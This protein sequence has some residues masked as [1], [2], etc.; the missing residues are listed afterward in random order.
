MYI[1]IDRFCLAPI[2][3]AFTPN[4]CLPSTNVCITCSQ[5]SSTQTSQHLPHKFYSKDV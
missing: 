2:P 1:A 5:L 3:A 4:N